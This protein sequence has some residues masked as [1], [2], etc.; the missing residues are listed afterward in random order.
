MDA[1]KAD[2][3]QPWLKAYPPG[4]DWHARFAEAP[5]YRF[6]ETDRSVAVQRIA[7]ARASAVNVQIPPRV[8]V[9]VIFDA[10]LSPHPHE[11]SAPLADLYLKDGPAAK[12]NKKA[13]SWQTDRSNIDRHI[14]LLLGRKAARM[15]MQ[16]D[17]AKF[18]ADVA[19]GKSKAD[20]KTRKRGRAI[21][22]GGRGTADGSRLSDQWNPAA[23]S[24][25]LAYHLDDQALWDTI[26]I[27]R[28]VM[29]FSLN[30][31]RIALLLYRTNNKDAHNRSHRMWTVVEQKGD[32]EF[33]SSIHK[34]AHYTATWPIIT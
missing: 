23:D 21:V 15:L 4:I 7:K 28:A 17:V 12:P 9:L 22:D 25:R 14:R 29:L 33:S 2:T 34:P 32:S 18:Q 3:E 5:L 11:L 8:D 10:V 24:P 31:Y 1:L 20:I 6:L 30:L 27:Y 13:S 16:H 19:A 26:Q